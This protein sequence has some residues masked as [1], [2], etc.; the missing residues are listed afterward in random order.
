VVFRW[1]RFGAATQSG[2]ID[3]AYSLNDKNIEVL[4]NVYD[5]PELFIPKYHYPPKDA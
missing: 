4:G 2:A 1:G 5:N 3:E